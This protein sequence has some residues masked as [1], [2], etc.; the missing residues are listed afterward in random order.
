MTDTLTTDQIAA[1]EMS[2]S[3]DTPLYSVSALC[4][5][6]PSLIAMAKSFIKHESPAWDANERM[7]D[8]VEELIKRAEKAE[9]E[10]DKFRTIVGRGHW[11]ATVTD[12]R[13]KKGLRGIRIKGEYPSKQAAL[14]AAEAAIADGRPDIGTF[15]HGPTAKAFARFNLPMCDIDALG[16]IAALL[17][18]V[19]S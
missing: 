18:E 5:A 11:T 13:P 4:V 17:E 8:T 7:N 16:D 12:N 10:R 1:L 2:L 14:R 9:A 6:A 15:I 3:S 19:K